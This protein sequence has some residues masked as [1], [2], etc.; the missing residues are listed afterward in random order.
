MIESQGQIVD[1][2]IKGIN[3]SAVIVVFVTTA[4]IE[5]VAGDNIADNCKKEFNYATLKRR[6]AR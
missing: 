2:M 5:K 3:A 1:Q 6:R 4:Y